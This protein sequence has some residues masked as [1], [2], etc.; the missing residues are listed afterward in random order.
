MPRCNFFLFFRNTNKI[1]A[2]LGNGIE[3]S[4]IPHH[5]NLTQ[6]SQ[7]SAEDYHQ[8]IEIIKGVKEDDYPKLGLESCSIK[9]ELNKVDAKKKKVVSVSLYTTKYIIYIKR[10]QRKLLLPVVRHP[11]NGQAFS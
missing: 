3:Q 2:L 1:V 5:I 8:M 6:V 7:V 4:L 11:T 9:D 10:V